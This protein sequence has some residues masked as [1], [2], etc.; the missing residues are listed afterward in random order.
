MDNRPR[1]CPKCNSLNLRLEGSHLHCGNPRCKHVY[2]DPDRASPIITA[3]CYVFW[4][5]LIIAAVWTL[6]ALPSCALASPSNKVNPT[7]ITE[8]NLDQVFDA[9]NSSISTEVRNAVKQVTNDLWPGVIG[10]TVVQLAFLGMLFFVGYRLLHHLVK[11]NSYLNQKPLWEGLK[12][13]GEA[14]RSAH[15]AA[16]RKD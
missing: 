15:E 11:S 12:T 9:H 16:M 3:L 4:G 14:L 5:A 2:R 6:L 13:N 7:A 10:T 1:V 8:A